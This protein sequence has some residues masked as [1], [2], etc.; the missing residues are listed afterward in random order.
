MVAGDVAALANE[1]FFLH[2][3]SVVAE[4]THP[5]FNKGS[6]MGTPFFDIRTPFSYQQHLPLL[7]ALFLFAY[8]HFSS[9]YTALYR[10]LVAP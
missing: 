1:A 8:V 10:H 5:H 3:D 6:D 4:L 9:H 7:Y 2:K